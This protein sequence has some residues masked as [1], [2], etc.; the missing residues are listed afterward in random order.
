MLSDCNSAIVRFDCNNVFLEFRWPFWLLFSEWPCFAVTGLDYWLWL[1]WLFFAVVNIFC[2]ILAFYHLEASNRR[3]LLTLHRQQLCLFLIQLW[4][5]DELKFMLC[6]LSA[7]NSSFTG[8]T[9]LVSHWTDCE[10]RLFLKQWIMDY[11]LWVFPDMSV[12]IFASFS[13]ACLF[14]AWIWTW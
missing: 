2:S 13:L 9:L 7:E 14:E 5:D 6:S 3:F 1:S 8:G 12:E 11:G 10:G 4:F